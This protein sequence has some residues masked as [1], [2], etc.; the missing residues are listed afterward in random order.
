MGTLSRATRKSLIQRG[1]PQ[2]SL[3]LQCRLLGLCRSSLYYRA[4]EPDTETLALMRRIDELYTAHPFYG[5]RKMSCHLVREGFAAGRDRVRRL[6]R[7]MGLE[8]IYCRPRTSQPH[9][10][11][12]SFHTCC[13]VCRSSVRTKCGVPTSPTF[14]CS[15][16]FL[17]LLS[18]RSD[19]RYYGNR[20]VMGTGPPRA[21][22]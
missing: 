21:V 7:T 8:A 16:G 17:Y 14:R 18:E 3:S 1:H 20:T 10:G 12:G 19:N 6:M 22:A 11:T 15:A 2:A 5:S 9:P 13:G 4:R